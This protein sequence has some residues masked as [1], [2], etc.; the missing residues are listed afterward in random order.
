MVQEAS[1]IA[2][3]FLILHSYKKN[4]QKWTQLEQ[5]FHQID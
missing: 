2:P 4:A 1:I 5:Y 3:Y